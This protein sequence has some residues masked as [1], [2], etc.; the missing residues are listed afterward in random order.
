[1]KE[2][3][4]EFL[5]YLRIGQT[6]FEEKVGLSRGMINKIKGNISLDSLQKITNAYPELNENWLRTGEGSMLK[7]KQ[8]EKCSELPVKLST[9]NLGVS[10]LINAINNISEATLK[11]AESDKIRAEADL[12]R[13]DAEQRNSKNMEEMIRLLKEE[14]AKVDNK[15]NS[16]KKEILT[17]VRKGN[18]DDI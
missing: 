4:V 8:S 2:R 11:N 3:L 17:N 15:S 7:E 1:M 9:D 10:D 18:F 12:K 13:A 6:K 14:R 5:A 16:V